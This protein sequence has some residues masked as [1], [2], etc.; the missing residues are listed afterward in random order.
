ME[1][2]RFEQRR[3][4]AG[5]RKCACVQATAAALASHGPW[6]AC[7][8]AVSLTREAARRGRIRVAAQSTLMHQLS[9]TDRCLPICWPNQISR[10]APLQQTLRASADSAA[11]HTAARIM[12]KF[13]AN[14][15]K[16]LDALHADSGG[17]SGYALPFLLFMS[18]FAE[19]RPSASG[20]SMIVAESPPSFVPR[21]L[22]VLL[23]LLQC[24]TGCLAPAAAPVRLLAS[25][26]PR[27]C[28]CAAAPTRPPRPP[29]AEERG[30]LRA[31]NAA[32]DEWG[33]GTNS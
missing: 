3:I 31:A 12:A 16:T 1:L 33:W 27:L 32:G 28:T 19:F 17:G 9:L 30:P 25:A 15:T 24:N 4:R 26:P 21:G 29:P 22:M 13:Q 10:S 18:P 11:P 20:R 8:C 5:K 14:S 7:R 2:A 23:V 6:P